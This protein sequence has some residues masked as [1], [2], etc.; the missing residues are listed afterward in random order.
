ML[1]CLQ[2][3]VKLGPYP[4]S[5]DYRHNVVT[6]LPPVE[7]AMIYI[8]NSELVYALRLFMTKMFHR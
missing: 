3:R 2:I 6:V 1:D 5:I 7:L 8:P 4:I